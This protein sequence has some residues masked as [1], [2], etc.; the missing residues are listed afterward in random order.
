MIRLV[1]RSQKNTD[2]TQGTFTPQVH[3]HAGRTGLQVRRLS[4]DT[5]QNRTRR[6]FARGTHFHYVTVA[7]VRRHSALDYLSPHQFECVQAELP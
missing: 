1:V 7:P 3:A 2:F 4:R 6:T 5:N